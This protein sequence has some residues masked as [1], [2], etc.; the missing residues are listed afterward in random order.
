MLLK[1]LVIFYFLPLSVYSHKPSANGALYLVVDKSD[2]TITLYDTDDWLI[3]WPC[4]FG[5]SDMGDKMMQGDRKTPEGT[6]SISGKYPH[7]KW[8]KFMRL[9]YPTKEDYAKFEDR[10][11]RGLIPAQAKIGGDIGIHG[12]WPREEWA[13]DNLQAWT[14]GCISMKNED[15]NELYSM[16]QVGT[17]VII[18]K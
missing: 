5:S 10:K 13:V 12:T 15:L 4:T 1:H 6:F 17:T 18:R 7:K 3:Q 9:N 2:N 11:K 16:I 8:N 14:M